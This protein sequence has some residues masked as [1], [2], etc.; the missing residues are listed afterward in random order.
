MNYQRIHDEIIGRARLR[1]K[2]AV[3]CE[4]HHI[5]PKSMGG[6]D[7]KANL[8]WL[9]A[10]E[11]Y[12]VH[13]LLF[14]IHRNKSMAF[15][16]FRMTTGLKKSTIR[17]TSATFHLAR[18]ANALFRGGSNNPMAGKTLSTEHREKMSRA[19]LG[20]TYSEM[21]RGPS[22]LAGR[23]I[24]EEHRERVRAAVIGRR[25]SPE[26]REKLRMSKL[27]SNNPQ[28][29]RAPSEI[30]RAKLSASLNAYHAKT[31]QLKKEQA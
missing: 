23:Q 22:K 11:H 16:W 24:T 28:F 21:G 25:H 31:R 3:Y 13:W 18:E 20:R 17:Y 26:A 15:A 30:T 6:S 7:E 12:L 2:P 14:K 4:R 27:G 1:E 5:V 29:G 8:I 19:K 10:K 9:T